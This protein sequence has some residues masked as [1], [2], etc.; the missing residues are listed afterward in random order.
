MWKINLEKAGEKVGYGAMFFIFTTILYF[1]LKIFE[2]IPPSWNYWYVAFLS[3]SI[4][5]FGTLIK[6]AVR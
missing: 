5:L 3:L 4:V 6:M 2:K 1:A